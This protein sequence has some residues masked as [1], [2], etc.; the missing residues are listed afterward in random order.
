MFSTICFLMSLISFYSYIGILYSK[1]KIDSISQS[2]YIVQPNYIFSIWIILTSLLIFPTWVEFSPEQ[3]QF[4]SFIS[5]VFL[6]IVGISPRY[7]GDDKKI[8]TIS[9]IATCVISIIYTIITQGYY[10][11]ILLLLLIVILKLLKVNNFL[12]WL[13]TIAFSNIYLTLGLKLL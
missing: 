4:L 12:F 7:L 1:H 11:L 8:H 3:Y 5:I 6:I 10:I 2:Y 9:A 13:E